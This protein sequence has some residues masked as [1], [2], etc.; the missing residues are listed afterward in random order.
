MKE[1]AESASQ[2]APSSA[3]VADLNCE[4]KRMWGNIRPDYI[5]DT[6]TNKVHSTQACLFWADAIE[7]GNQVRLEMDLFFRKRRI[8]GRE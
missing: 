8:C 4:V 2:P 7:M 3:S 1:N 5:R 6:V